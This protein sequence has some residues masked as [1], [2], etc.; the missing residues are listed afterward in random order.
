MTLA[1]AAIG[2]HL[3][4]TP[5]A[6]RFAAAIF[7]QPDALWQI[8]LTA[9]GSGNLGLSAAHAWVTLLMVASS[10]CATAWVLWGVLTLAAGP[11]IRRT[12]M[13]LAAV[14]LCLSAGVLAVYLVHLASSPASPYPSLYRS[15]FGYWLDMSFEGGP[16][17]PG[18]Q[19]LALESM[20]PVMLMFVITRRPAKE[21]FSRKLRR[22]RSGA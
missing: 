17:I 15:S 4:W 5:T 21:L 11:R 7:H 16:L 19:Q 8:F 14:T 12:T 1:V 3:F 13:A 22:L 2:L 10:L 18:V 20:F 9:F 6:A